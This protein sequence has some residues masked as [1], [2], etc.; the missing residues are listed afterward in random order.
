MC[1]ILLVTTRQRRVRMRCD[2]CGGERLTR[3]GLDRSGR[4]LHRC[5]A[6]G[7]RLTTRS[8]AATCG[9]RFPDEVV[10]LAVR[11]Y[12]RFRLSYAD[13]AELLAERGIV[14]D[15]STVYDWVQ[16][17]TPRFTSRRPPGPIAHPSSGRGT[18]TRRCARSP[19]GGATSS[20]LSMGTARAWTS[21]RA[22][23]AMRRQRRHSSREPWRQR[24]PDP[25]GCPRTR[26]RATRRPC[27]RCC[28]TPNTAPPRT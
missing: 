6:C 19:G 3:A 10:A 5:A 14:V 11:W 9:Y 2:R 17:F 7:R 27:A 15:P 25:G 23:T 22:A 24:R 16:A 13:L 8:A 12:L 26:P 20:E 28:L 4:Q 21:T 18:S 1:G